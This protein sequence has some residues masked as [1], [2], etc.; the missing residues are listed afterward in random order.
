MIWLPNLSCFGVRFLAIL[1]GA[2]YFS[3]GNVLGD[4]R[5]WK[6]ASGTQQIIAEF[7]ELRDGHVYLRQVGDKVLKAPLK[8]LSK[9]DRNYLGDLEALS[10]KFDMPADKRL[11]A[12]TW[13]AEA[14][15]AYAMKRRLA[16]RVRADYRLVVDTSSL[17]ADEWVAFAAYPPNTD[18]QFVRSEL[19]P[20]ADKVWEGQGGTR[21]LW[22]SRIR[23]TNSDLERRFAARMRLEAD[24]YSRELVDSEDALNVVE[25]LPESLFD[26]YTAPTALIDFLSKDLAKWSDTV[27]L[28]RQDHESQ[29]D[30]ARRVYRTIQRGFTYSYTRKMDRRASTVSRLK[31]SDCGGLSILFLSILRSNDIPARLLV[32]RWAKS[33]EPGDKLEGLDYEQQHVKSEFFAAGVGWIPV[34][35]SLGVGDGKSTDPNFFGKDPGDFITLHFDHDIAVDTIHFGTESLTWLQG[36]NYWVAGTGDLSK[37]RIEKSWTVADLKN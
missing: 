14:N 5:L 22:R 13:E 20:G 18:G 19:L 28:D 29:V 15:S 26:Q 27:G 9:E 34:D 10:A 35:M 17:K 32:G 7:S 30:F 3:A 16:R 8:D 33:A 25:P 24:L 36:I 11:L 12:Y 21:S 23:A 6:N 4:M 1:A 31:T 37:V 2:V